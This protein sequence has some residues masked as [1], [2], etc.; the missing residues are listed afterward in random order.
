MANTTRD[1]GLRTQEEL[2]EAGAAYLT[3]LLDEREAVAAAPAAAAAEAAWE[4]EAAGRGRTRA[5]GER[6]RK[7]RHRHRKPRDDGSAAAGG[8]SRNR[9]RR[10]GSRRGFDGAEPQAGPRDAAGD[11]GLMPA[12]DGSAAF[13]AA[14]QQP[15]L[16][17]GS[18]S[19]LPQPQLHM[20]LSPTPAALPTA[21]SPYQPPPPPLSAAPA[22]SP[23]VQRRP[24]PQGTLGQPPPPQSFAQ[25][26]SSASAAHLRGFR[27]AQVQPAAFAA[28]A[29]A[30]SPAAAGSDARGFLEAFRAE[31]PYG[32][33]ASYGPE[34]QQQPAYLQGE[35]YGAARGAAM[36]LS[37]PSP[38]A[39]GASAV[40]TAAALIGGIVREMTLGRQQQP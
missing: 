39:D 5:G 32:A 12:R 26:Q 34:A 18:P 20:Q 33:P 10:T 17:A 38:G 36:P 21:A 40:Q 24:Q 8:A 37:M 4:E 31:Q 14:A 16:A 9:A 29:P 35:M 22:G 30:G 1:G 27:Q 11:E 15:P 13:G 28:P 7:S 25:P 23:M 3:E 6:R 19:P 2:V